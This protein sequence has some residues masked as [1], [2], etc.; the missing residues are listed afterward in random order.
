MALYG[1]PVEGYANCWPFDSE[2][3]HNLELEPPVDAA[4]L[5]PL[6][7]TSAQMRVALGTWEMATVEIC[8]DSEHPLSAPARIRSKTKGEDGAVARTGIVRH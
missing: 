6:V 2:V 1:M 8:R 7:V 3:Q 4:S 5:P